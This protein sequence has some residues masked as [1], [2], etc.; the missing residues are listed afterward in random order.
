MTECM[1]VVEVDADEVIMLGVVGD[2]LADALEL[3]E[4]N[5]SQYEDPSDEQ[6]SQLES[7]V[8]ECL[9]GS[10]PWKEIRFESGVA[11]VDY[12]IMRTEMKL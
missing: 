7:N 10:E 5:E 6:R 9:D 3:I 4:A 1:V 12:M 2:S 11:S 8:A